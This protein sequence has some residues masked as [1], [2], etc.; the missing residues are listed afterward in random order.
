M[1]TIQR[2]QSTL[3]TLE[4]LK[5]DETNPYKEQ[6]FVL[7]IDSIKEV[8]RELNKMETLSKLSA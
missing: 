1:N 8:I 3:K 4:A 7:E 6:L 2:L 5:N